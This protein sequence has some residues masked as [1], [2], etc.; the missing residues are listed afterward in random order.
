MAFFGDFNTGFSIGR[1]LARGRT[2]G[3][4]SQTPQRE[5]RDAIIQQLYPG[6]V[7]G[8]VQWGIRFGENF[9]LTIVS[10]VAIVIVAWALF[11]F[12]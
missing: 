8:V 3:G 9:F 1:H 6:P 5:L 7:T 2:L 12:R 4:P 10:I 11:F